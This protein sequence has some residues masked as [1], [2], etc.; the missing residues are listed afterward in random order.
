M[1]VRD[2][3]AALALVAAGWW[4]MEAIDTARRYVS[5]MPPCPRCGKRWACGAERC[6]SCLWPETVH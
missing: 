2:V 4:A 3:L 1:R 6:L 5:P